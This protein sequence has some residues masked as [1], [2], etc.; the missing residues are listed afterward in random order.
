M[1]AA[2]DHV[3]SDAKPL[4]RR[5]LKAMRE[6]S[7]VLAELDGRNGLDSRFVIPIVAVFADATV[8]EDMWA[9]IQAAAGA[10]KCPAGLKPNLEQRL[11]SLRE[12]QLDAAPSR[13]SHSMDPPQTCLLYTSPSPRDS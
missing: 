1:L 12:A 7:Q 10:L 13:D 11:Q 6:P 2:T 8:D 3:E 4:P 9:R 5:A